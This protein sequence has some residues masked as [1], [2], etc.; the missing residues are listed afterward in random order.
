MQSSQ[1]ATLIGSAAWAVAC[2]FGAQNPR[3]GYVLAVSWLL[4]FAA[5]SAFSIPLWPRERHRG[6]IA[7]ASIFWGISLGAVAPFFVKIYL[8]E[9]LGL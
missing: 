3:V 2:H 1:R 5:S 7:V 4:V 6:H 9:L 8:P